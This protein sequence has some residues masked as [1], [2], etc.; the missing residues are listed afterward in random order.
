L[1]AVKIRDHIEQKKRPPRTRDASYQFARRVEASASFNTAMRQA[2][3]RLEAM[4]FLLDQCLQVFSA[5]A[6]GIYELRGDTLVYSFG[7]GL[8]EDPP[9]RVPADTTTVLGRTLS[10]DRVLHFET[11][12][13][14]ESNCDICG[15]LSDQGIR[16]LF[17]SPLRTSKKSIGVLFI[18]MK[19]K[20]A[21][22]HN[23]EQLLNIFSEAAGNTLHRFLVVEQVEQT[24]ANR[25]MELQLLYDLMTIAG[26]TLDMDLLLQKSLRRILQATDCTI[27]IIHFVDPADKKLKISVNEHLSEELHNYLLISGLSEHLWTKVYQSQK[28]VSVPH[29]PDRSFP[30][31]PSAERQY[32]LYLGVPIR[33]KNNV[34]GV[35][36]LIGQS[37]PFCS[38]MTSQLVIS[39]A[40]V[41]GL[42]VETLHFRKQAED[43]AILNER[44]RLG[45]NLHDSVSQS[46]YALVVSSDVSEKLLRIKNYPG[47]RQELKDMCKLALQGLKD[48]RLILYDFRPAPLESMGIEKALELRFNSVECRAGIDVSLEVEHDIPL[49]PKMEQEIYQVAI[50]SLNNSLRYAEATSVAISLMKDNHGIQLEIQDNGCGFDPSSPNTAGGMG[51][52][53]M[54]ARAQILGGEL[55]ISST[56]GKGTRVCLKVPLTGSDKPKE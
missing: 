1:S 7:I 12:T 53:N 20:I 14:S 3:S 46:L 15:F 10:L 49:S 6:A 38:P 8:M 45:R 52:E 5:D 56:S 34:V 41:L 29:L 23:D 25:D 9:S 42:A 37:D 31:V 4:E 19:R 32:Y 24:V 54:H 40:D 27:G 26:E 51:L 28:F 39:A 50:E 13:A 47:L 36:S 21:L 43:A 48:M 22:S 30:E 55:V 44:Q 16:S 11:A 35:L 2:E 18:A 17:I 33:I